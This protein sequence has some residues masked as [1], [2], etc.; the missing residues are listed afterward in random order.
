MA[1][2]I[3]DIAQRMSD[4]RVPSARSFKTVSPDPP[5]ED[6]TKNRPRDAQFFRDRNDEAYCPGKFCVD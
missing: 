5:S 3:S 1:A 6:K 2:R 4:L